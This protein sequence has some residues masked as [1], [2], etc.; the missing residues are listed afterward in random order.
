MH[1]LIELVK[2]VVWPITVLTIFVI[3]RSEVQRFTKNVA[4]RIQSANSITIGPRGVELKGLVKVVPV[5]AELQ[6]RKLA[7]ARFV[8]RLTSK[9]TLDQIAEAL[10]IP[11][12]TDIKSQIGDIILEI[13]RRVD[14]GQ[15]MDLLSQELRRIT[16][17]DF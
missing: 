7:L 11:Q 1:E 9:A 13:N 4:D 3:L 5:P 2:A 15:A 8:R 16:A 10:N 6:A 14:S 17:Q 12:S